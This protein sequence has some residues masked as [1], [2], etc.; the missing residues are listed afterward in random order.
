MW[1]DRFAP[2]N[3][4]SVRQR[5]GLS[6]CTA[7]WAVSAVASSM[8]FASSILGITCSYPDFTSK[9]TDFGRYTRSHHFP[10][11]SQFHPEVLLGLQKGSKVPRPCLLAR[12][13][14][15]SRWVSR[16]CTCWGLTARTEALS[17]GSCSFFFFKQHTL[18]C[19]LPLPGWFC[20]R[21]MVR[22][23]GRGHFPR[24]GCA[25][26]QPLPTLGPSSPSV[27]YTTRGCLRTTA[28]KLIRVT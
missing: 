5:R 27:Q 1:S 25:N 7:C 26:A 11:S 20:G 6:S 23:W 22:I 4:Y 16:R 17:F 21:G 8:C 24:R 18:C 12:E 3:C 15:R 13:K 10:Q 28:R 2:W 14:P 19:F 9:E